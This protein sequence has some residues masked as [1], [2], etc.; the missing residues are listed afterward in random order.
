MFGQF[1]AS[2]QFFL[3]GKK[4]FTRTGWEAARARYPQPDA[5]TTFELEGKCYMVT[6]ANQARALP[7]MLRTSS[8]GAPLIPTLL[9]AASSMV[10]R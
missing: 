8:S 4:H 7:P 2:T 1:A 10:L 5:L 6:G 3:Y 9:C